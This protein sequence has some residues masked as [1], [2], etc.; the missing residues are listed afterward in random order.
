M[1]ELYFERIGIQE[2]NVSEMV[3]VGGGWI[4]FARELFRSALLSAAWEEAKKAGKAWMAWL[5]EN[6]NMFYG[7][8]QYAW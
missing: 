4:S 1:D 2:M 7:P 3:E 6:Q 8:E 5:E